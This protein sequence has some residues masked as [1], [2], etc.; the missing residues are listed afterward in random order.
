[1][2]INTLQVYDN[3]L[4]IRCLFNVNA[5]QLQATTKLLMEQIHILDID[6]LKYKPI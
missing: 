5:L 6:A 4:P 3:E 2:L 1:M